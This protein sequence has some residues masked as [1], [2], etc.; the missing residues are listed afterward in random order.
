MLGNLTDS[1][2]TCSLLDCARN[3]VRFSGGLPEPEDFIGE[4]PGD[5]G[6]GFS[7]WSAMSESPQRGEPLDGRPEIAILAL[8]LASVLGL[9]VKRGARWQW[10]PALALAVGGTWAF[11]SARGFFLQMIDPLPGGRGAF[12]LPGWFAPWPW[13]LIGVAA[14]LLGAAAWRGRTNGAKAPSS[15]IV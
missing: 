6:C 8:I 13:L 9:A 15:C 1:V 11:L 5:L 3:S 12:S 14:A 4:D 10:V 7:L 2:V